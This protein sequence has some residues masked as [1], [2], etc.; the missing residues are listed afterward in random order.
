MKKGLAFSVVAAALLV[1]G[2]Y[3]G[4]PRTPERIVHSTLP[5]VRGA[6]T[7]LN[8]T[9]RHRQW[10]NIED[11]SSSIRAFIVYPRRSNKAPV[12]VVSFRDL[13]V[14]AQRLDNC[15]PLCRLPGAE[16]SLSLSSEPSRSRDNP[17]IA[18]DSFLPD[19]ENGRPLE[20]R[21]SPVHHL[22][23]RVSLHG[24]WERQ[25]GHQQEVPFREYPE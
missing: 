6:K 23:F 9:Y 3:L 22:W 2:I 12:V 10:I 21:S 17:G 20:D 5:T 24:R 11:G 13:G 19:C 14:L 16:L 15:G 18:V 8:A 7:V 4:M 25:L 1:T